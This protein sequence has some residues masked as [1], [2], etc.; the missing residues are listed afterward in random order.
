MRLRTVIR[1]REVLLAGAVWLACAGSGQ[2]GTLVF[3]ATTSGQQALDRDEKGG[4]PFASALIESLDQPS[5]RISDL[6][7]SL[8]RLTLAYSRGHQRAGL[9]LAVDLDARSLEPQTTDQRRVALVLVVSDYRRAGLPSLAGARFDADRI[10][11]ALVRSGFATETVIDLD[12]PAMLAKL[13]AFASLSQLKDVAVIYTTGHGVE[14][15]GTVHLLPGDY[16]VEKKNHGLRQHAVD[17]P[18]IATAARASSLNLVFYGGCR[19]N[20]LAD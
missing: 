12:R 4:N 13:D 10:A 16:P 18:R 3:H 1:L 5:L 9:P 7:A 15:D 6:K 14:V 11:R 20:P 8:E 19:D 2:A 17:L